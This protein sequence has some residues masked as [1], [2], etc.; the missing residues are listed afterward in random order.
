M[1]EYEPD[2]ELRDTE[3][4]PLQEEGGI[5]AFLRR[6]VLPY[7]ADAWY[8]PESVKVGYEIS[9]NRYFYSR[10]RCDLGGNPRRHLGAGEGDRGSSGRCTLQETLIMATQRYSVTPHAIET[11]LTWVKSGEIAI[12]EIQRP[13]VWDAT[14]VRNLLDS[15]YQGYPVG[16]LIAWAQSRRCVSRTVPGPQVNVSSSTASSG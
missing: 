16:Y 5:E 9:F 1:V 3:Q 4:I 11:L 14:K 12:P 2:T 6:E 8:P 13:F 7:A 10:N 15:L